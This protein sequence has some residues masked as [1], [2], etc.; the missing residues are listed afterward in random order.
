M[1]D[2]LMGKRVELQA[3]ACTRTL[4]SKELFDRYAVGDQVPVVV[5][6]VYEL[7]SK[8]GTQ[9]RECCGCRIGMR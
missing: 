8:N 3:N 4:Q 9:Y 2:D 6:T 1:Q 5:T 7:R